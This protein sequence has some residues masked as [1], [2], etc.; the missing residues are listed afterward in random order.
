[1]RPRR[2]SP[3]RTAPS[4]RQRNAVP[5]LIA[6]ARSETLEVHVSLA[7]TPLPRRPTR[8]ETTPVTMK[9]PRKANAT[10]EP[11]RQHLLD[12]R[13]ALLRLHKALLDAE[14]AR[15]ERVHGRINGPGAFLQ[16][17]LNDPWFGWLRPLSQLVVQID[18]RLDAE[19]AVTAAEA[20]AFIVLA[21]TTLHEGED[22][23]AFPSHYERALQEAPGVAGPYGDVS[24]LIAH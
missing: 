4:L 14:R 16:L 9:P 18:E 22:E 6:A 20:N 13:G 23:A 11:T 1:M 5:R 19:E 21:R 15:Y 3:P 7:N 2:P 17:L 10:P 8:Q 12:V 24:K